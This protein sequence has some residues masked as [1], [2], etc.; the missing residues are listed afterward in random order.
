MASTHPG[1]VSKALKNHP[2][3]HYFI[4]ITSLARKFRFH[5][6]RRDFIIFLRE[7]AFQVR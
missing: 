4:E 6:R 7:P 3:N 2:V 5:S 1:L